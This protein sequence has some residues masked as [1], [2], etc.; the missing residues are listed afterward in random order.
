M[1]LICFLW[2]GGSSFYFYFSYF[3]QLRRQ[4]A[5]GLNLTALDCGV[6]TPT[7]PR[8][9]KSSCIH[10][11]HDQQWSNTKMMKQKKDTDQIKASRHRLQN[12]GNPRPHKQGRYMKKEREGKDLFIIA[13]LLLVLL[14]VL[15]VLFLYVR[16]R[17]TLPSPRT[18][19]GNL[20]PLAC[21]RARHLTRPLR[22]AALAILL[23]EMN[24]GG[25]ADLL[26]TRPRPLTLWTVLPAAER[27]EFGC[28][29]VVHTDFTVEVV[30]AL[31]DGEEVGAGFA[32]FDGA[33]VV[34]RV[35]L[36]VG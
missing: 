20:P 8:G 30:A 24:R 3:R 32:F 22:R 25:L 31:A 26:L 19:T 7:H 9:G 34:F 28:A 1:R 36:V 29:R 13:L 5:G 16:C 27:K 2:L 17:R 21:T 12:A 15:L 33:E 23:L 18:S 4:R 35:A 14:L 10:H 11:S 6:T